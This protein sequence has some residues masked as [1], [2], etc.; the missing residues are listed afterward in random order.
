MKSSA[1]T[2]KA[3]SMTK[4][5]RELPSSTSSLMA[6]VSISFLSGILVSFISGEDWSKILI[7]GAKAVLL[8]SFP[9]LFT[10]SLFIL[11]KKTALKRMLFLA[12]LSGLIYSLFYT[13]F[14]LWPIFGSAQTAFAFLL[15]SYGIV[16]AL[17]F[18]VA[19]IFFSFSTKTSILF[20]LLQLVFN[21][22]LMIFSKELSLSSSIT[23]IFIQFIL[24]S[25]LFL[26]GVYALF[27]FINA[28]IRRNFGVSGIDALA[29]FMSHWLEKGD[30]LEE[31][32]DEVGEKIT[33]KISVLVI[34]GKSKQCLLIVPHVH[35]GPFG[36]L[37][38][39]DFPNLISRE[40]ENKGFGCMVFHGLATHDFNPVCSEEV[41]EINSSIS[42]CLSKMNFSKAKGRFIHGENNEEKA[43]GVIINKDGFVFLSRAPSTSEDIEFSWA[44]VYEN[45]LK[46]YGFKNT[47]IFDA[48]NADTGEIT[49]VDAGSPIGFSY[50][51]IIEK[52]GKAGIDELEEMKF[53]FKKFDFKSPRIGN[54]GMKAIVFEIGK[55][56]NA[57]ILF[58]SNGMTPE[59]GMQIKEKLESLGLEGDGFTTDTHS[60][61]VVSGVLN[62]L[63]FDN[64]ENAKILNLLEEIPSI[65][66]EEFEAGMCEETI[67]LKVFGTK[68]SAELIGT[69]NSIIALL[70]IVAPLLFIL[71]IALVFYLA[72][73]AFGGIV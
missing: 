20:S 5:F 34:K 52:I 33:T 59:F 57:Y 39:S 9:S 42:K 35:F 58:D 31:L 45:I 10:I 24:I 16:F 37:G 2:E 43:G 38:G 71:I 21:L 69:I 48:H 55:K 73:K 15:V 40:F 49:R 23:S 18:I 27:W 30:E 11:W 44:L 41:L 47:F 7:S 3:V 67:D 68:Q 61:N 54:A 29:F 63:G 65:K 25:L 62:P 36:T 14:Y 53:G 32:F 22:Y 17:W 6:L 72:K 51:E 70:K 4:Y 60:I 13:A 26:F 46:K 64:E 28:P 66:T 1:A 50:I 19:R 56:K 12:F 8:I